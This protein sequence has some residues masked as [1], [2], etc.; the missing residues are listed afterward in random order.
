MTKNTI[1]CHPGSK[2]IPFAAKRL[3]ELG[4]FI[5]DVPGKNCGHLLLPVPSFSGGDDDLPQLL[6]K[7]PEDVTV[8]GGNLNSRYL[9]QYKAVDF[10]K[11][12]DYLAENAAITARC[13][14]DMINKRIPLPQRKVLLL[15]WGR[16]GKCLGFLLREKKAA[17]TI[18][19]RKDEDL[20]MIRALG[21]EAVPS[22][23]IAEDLT[24]YDSIVNT[25]PAMV[26][27]RFDCHPGCVLLELAS[28]PG[29]KHEGIINGRG[30]P[31]RMAP[32]ESGK[33]IAETFIRLSIS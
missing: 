32:E 12:P 14:L 10:L 24:M 15:G 4:F 30:L 21:F 9:A 2:A 29:M 20:A 3:V 31:G 22:H 6:N 8:S 23:G 18:A 19:A 16:I 7:L 17:V 13:A 28:Q 26:L 25:I 11:D 33:L 27:P 1:Y 5:A